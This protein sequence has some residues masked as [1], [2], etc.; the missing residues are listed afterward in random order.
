[1]IH[2]LI[3]QQVVDVTGLPLLATKLQIPPSPP[4]RKWGISFAVNGYGSSLCKGRLGGILGW[5]SF[6]AINKISVHCEVV[7][8]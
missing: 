4:L 3:A 7:S 6:I 5:V 8:A 2:Y 1:M